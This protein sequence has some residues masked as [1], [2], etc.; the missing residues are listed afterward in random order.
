M[1]RN[2]ISAVVR[3]APADGNTVVIAST[4][5]PDR[6]D[7][8]V[9]Q[10]WYLDRY[11]TNPVILWAHDPTELPVGK[12][13]R[14]DVEDGRLVAEIEWD[15]SHPKGAD[16][17]RQFREGFLSAVSVGFRPGR[18]IPRSQ[19]PPEDPRRKDGGWGVVFLDN[20]LL[21]ISAVP[22][23]ANPDAVAVQRAEE[24]QATIIETL[25]RIIEADRAA[26]REALAEDVRAA[27]RQETA[28]LIAAV[29]EE[30]RA[31]LAEDDMEEEAR[32]IE[33]ADPEWFPESDSGDWFTR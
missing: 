31:A 3:A 26:M 20:E 25:R 21:E 10:S 18:S 17:A 23:P 4:A 8:V 14:V 27:V 11:R 32:G 16:V 33:R 6:M 24:D 30:I 22:I 19:L 2:T 15:E 7:D 13:V 9:D 29:G 1:R 28:A 5:T 12:A